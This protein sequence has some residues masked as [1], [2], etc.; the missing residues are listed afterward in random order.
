VGPASFCKSD[1][2]LVAVKGLIGCRSM[3]VRQSSEEVR[4]TLRQFL[5][6]L[7]VGVLRFS[8]R[9]YVPQAD[10]PLMT[11]PPSWKAVGPTFE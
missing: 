3:D 9:D 10:F 1:A 6:L 5:A 7:R 2:R 8:W 4:R 11:V